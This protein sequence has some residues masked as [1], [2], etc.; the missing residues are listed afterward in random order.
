MSHSD[1]WSQ[2]RDINVQFGILV[3]SGLE[4]A[5]GA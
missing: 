5:H 1:S 3:P 2:D 4:L